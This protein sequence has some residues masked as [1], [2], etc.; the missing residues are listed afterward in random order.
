MIYVIIISSLL[1]VVLIVGII[2]KLTKSKNDSKEDQVIEIDSECC[3]TCITCEKELK[4]IDSDI[5]YFE[6]EE[7]DEFKNIEADSY[8]DE[9]IDIFRDVLYTLKKDEVNDWLISLNKR[10]IA[11]P[12]I[13][14]QEA[15]DILAA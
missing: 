1:A 5:E 12:N 2:S 7:L 13:L 11:L 14:K 15:I 6:D 10:K 8:Q 9:Q 3:G 4:K